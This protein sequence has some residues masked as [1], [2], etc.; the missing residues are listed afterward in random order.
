MR[1][2]KELYITE[3]GF[4]SVIIIYYIIL[5]GILFQGYTHNQGNVGGKLPK[6]YYKVIR[7]LHA[8]LDI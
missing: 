5:L 8:C 6:V 4:F 3:V 7:R 2:T 1:K